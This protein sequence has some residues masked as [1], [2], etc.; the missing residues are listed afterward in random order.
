MVQWWW[1]GGPAVTT[2]KRARRAERGKNSSGLNG[3]AE[4][5][6]LL[7]FR[8]FK[9]S[10]RIISHSSCCSFFTIS[11][12][13]LLAASTSNFL[14]HFNICSICNNT[15]LSTPPLLLSLPMFDLPLKGQTSSAD[16]ARGLASEQSRRKAVWSKMSQK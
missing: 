12:L 10:F 8:F 4:I 5:H 9:I 16:E 7:R 6:T 13:F 14:Y 11:S 15:V 2:E 1:G 3:T